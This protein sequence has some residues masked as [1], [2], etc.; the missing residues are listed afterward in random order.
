MDYS[1]EH[2]E[3]D[4]PVGQPGEEAEGLA[5]AAAFLFQV[6]RMTRA[7]VVRANESVLFLDRSEG[8]G[9]N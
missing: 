4:S 7:A 8:N 5:D 9:Q 6:L 2:V 1:E 3:S